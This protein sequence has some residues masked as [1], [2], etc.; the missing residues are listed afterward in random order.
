MITTAFITIVY[1]FIFAIT[2]PLR[3]L[4]DVSLPGEVNSAISTAG[5]YLGTLNQI[6]P[7]N[8]LLTIFGLFLAIEVFILTYKLIMWVI[9]KIPGIN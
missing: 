7:V 6:F 8:T 9:R 5:G 3:L 1:A 2:A 4:P